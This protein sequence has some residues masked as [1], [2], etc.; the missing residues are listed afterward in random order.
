VGKRVKSPVKNKTAFLSCHHTRNYKVSQIPDAGKESWCFRCQCYSIVMHHVL[1]FGFKCMG[2]RYARTFG[3]A[4]LNM[5]IAASRHHRRFPTH[6]VIGFKGDEK[7]HTWAKVDKQDN[8]SNSLFDSDT[9]SEI[10]PF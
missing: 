9:E 1:D 6:E 2:C 7:L 5:E 10:P 8:G 3:A 4:R